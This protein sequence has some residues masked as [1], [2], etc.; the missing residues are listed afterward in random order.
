MNL[1]FNSIFSDVELNYGCPKCD[2]NIVFT[3]S[4]S[5]STV[6]CPECGVKIQFNKSDD[7]QNSIE[8]MNKI[9]SDF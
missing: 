5:T 3:L 9:L 1:N 2:S 7:F 6:N 8:D 4:D